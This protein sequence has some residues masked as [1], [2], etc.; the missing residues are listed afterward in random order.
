MP[1][2]GEIRIDGANQLDGLLFAHQSYKGRADRTDAILDRADLFL[3]LRPSRFFNVV[4]AGSSI[5]FLKIAATENWNL[6]HKG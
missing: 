6:Y 5:S 2:S 3:Q 1:A 4:P